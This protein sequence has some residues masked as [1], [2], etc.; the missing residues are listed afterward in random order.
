MK[1]IFLC[2]IFSCFIF[3]SNSYAQ[4]RL[5]LVIGNGDYYSVPSLSNPVNDAKYMAIVLKNL[6]FKVILKL[7][8]SKKAMKK[9]VREFGQGL[10]RDD[11]ALFYYSGYGLQ[12]NN[13]NYLI[14]V[15]AN[16]KGYNNIKFEGFDVKKVLHKMQRANGDGVNIVI[17]DAS[18][19]NPFQS[20]LIRKGL[21]EM[22]APL[23]FLLAY[24]TLPNEIASNSIYTTYLLNALSNNQKVSMSIFEMLKKVTMQVAAKTNRKQTPWTSYALTKQFCFGNCGVACPK[25]SQLLNV[26]EKHLQANRLTSGKGGTALQCYQEVLKKDHTNKKALAGLDKIEARYVRWTEGALNNGRVNK[27]KQ[28]IESLREVKP[29]SLKLAKLEKRVYTPEEIKKIKSVST[30]NRWSFFET[31]SD[32]SSSLI[33]SIVKIWPFLLIVVIVIP[34][35]LFGLLRKQEQVQR[36]LAFNPFDYFRLLWWMLVIPQQLINYREK[37]GEADEMR[38]SKWLTSSLIWLPLL[39]PNL[40]LGLELFSHA[41]NALLP[42]TFFKISAGLV[43]CW[44]LVGWLGDLDKDFAFLV[45][46]LVAFGMGFGV[47]GIVAGGVVVIVAVIVAVL[48]AFIVAFVRSIGFAFFVAFI[49]AAGMVAHLEAGIE[50]GLE[51]CVAGIVMVGIAFFVAVNVKASLTN[52]KVSWLARFAFLL[53]ISAHLFLIYYCFLGGLGL[54]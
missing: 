26:C 19:N 30:N 27:A 44:L 11:V 14:P 20:N 54:F 42:E 12:F 28:Y 1:Y 23:G 36:F 33:N 53:L 3:A 37:F 13:Q 10:H 5:A 6:G 48:V 2:L 17:L 25:C 46:L 50:A 47:A 43:G 34:L 52:G 15:N 38:L 21:A 8:A 7:N 35:I 16:I 32:I 31:V 24:S 18:R 41:N 22:K 40:A 4:E 51:A 45:V 39:I 49:I 9:A 29:E